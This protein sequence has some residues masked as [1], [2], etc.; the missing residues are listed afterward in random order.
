M[1]NKI[2]GEG[3]YEAGRRFNKRQQEF[4][5]SKLNGKHV[6]EAIEDDLDL[7]AMDDANDIEIIEDSTQRTRRFDTDHS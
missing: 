3:D 2:Q 1:R 7:E 4:V 5:R 6:A